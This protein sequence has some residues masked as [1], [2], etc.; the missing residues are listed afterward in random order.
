MGLNYAL[1]LKE[2]TRVRDQVAYEAKANRWPT[3]FFFP[4]D[5]YIIAEIETDNKNPRY[6]YGVQ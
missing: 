2:I 1:H 5:S 6:A 3:H 4:P